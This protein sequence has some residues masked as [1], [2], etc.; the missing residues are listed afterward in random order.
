M[1]ATCQTDCPATGGLLCGCSA[2]VFVCLLRSAFPAKRSYL[3]QTHWNTDLG[4]SSLFGR[5][6][7]KYCFRRGVVPVWT[8]R[9]DIAVKNTAGVIGVCIESGAQYCFRF[10]Q[11]LR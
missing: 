6:T 7:E 10:Y 11:G 4:G 1:P 2:V 3:S 5:L 9:G 8:F